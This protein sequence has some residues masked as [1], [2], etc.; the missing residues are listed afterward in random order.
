MNVSITILRNQRLE[1]NHQ[2][3]SYFCFLKEG[4]LL[5]HG[6]Q[7]LEDQVNYMLSYYIL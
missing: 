6:N 2:E 4:L 7:E 1:R 3:E 5:L